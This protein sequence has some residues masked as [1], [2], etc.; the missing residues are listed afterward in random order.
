METENEIIEGSPKK[1]VLHLTYILAAINIVIF[2]LMM[3]MDQ[4][5]GV[6]NQVRF[7]AKV[8]YLIVD[9]EYYRLLSAMFLH[10]DKMHLA[11]NMVSLLNLGVSIEYIFGKTRFL[12]IYF[13]SGI[14]AS[15]GSFLFND[16]IAVG[17]SGAIFGLLGALLFF[18]LIHKSNGTK[19]RADTFVIIGTIGINLYYGF[20]TTS[21]DNAAHITGLIAGYLTC[22]AI[23]KIEV[24]PWAKYARVLSILLLASFTI[25][26]C[27]LGFSNYK[28]SESYYYNKALISFLLG[29]NQIGL[30]AL[31]TGYDKYHSERITKIVDELKK[32][33]D[34]K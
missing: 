29:K 1:R 16:N 27:T 3:L 5:N 31:V 2:G 34:I 19:L 24:I 26:G 8:N 23:L 32:G 20:T 22:W 11:F 30:T 17:A 21:I 15:I 6:L 12:A 4:Q 13:I 33:V 28:N 7:G 14:L 9:G 10:A 25:Y 18:T